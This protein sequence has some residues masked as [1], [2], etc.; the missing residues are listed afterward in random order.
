M[1]VFIRII[2]SLLPVIVFLFTLNY[3]DSF[4]LVRRR[5]VVTA[6]L[7]GIVVAIVSL[8]IN[9]A[10]MEASGWK[11]AIVTRY[12]APPIE[13]TLKAAW[14]A[15]LIARRRVGFMVDAAIVGFAVGTGFALVEN[16]YYIR[17]L[18]SH[19]IVVWAVR[20]LGTAVMHGGMTAI[21][22]LITRTL[23]DRHEGRFAS[24]L[25]ALGLVIAAHSLFNHFLLSP[26][27]STLVLHAVLPLI[28]L[29]VFWQSERT[30]RQWLG[31]QMDVDAEMLEIINSGTMSSSRIGRYLVEIRR[32]FEPAIVIDMLCY[33]RIRTELA[34]S[35]KGMLMM[36]EA[37]F[38]PA[39]PDGTR[40][41]FTE[42]KHLEKSIGV[43]GRLAMK[44]L[45]H[46]S[47]RDLWQ[48]Y[49]LDA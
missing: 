5:A 43:T 44:P 48:F 33:L 47:T 34:V 7:M 30:T 19:N 40:E 26:V 37:G 18:E 28:L 3:L 23:V 46:Q 16:A 8:A 31:R 38:K 10:V 24:Y 49:Q 29:A 12:V 15:W 27:V 13:E 17:V 45:L 14:V 6:L 4:Q 42:L 11:R 2:V 32:Q 20:G 1:D 35:A 25:P 9:D 36:K 22:G 39:P 21:Y 41:K